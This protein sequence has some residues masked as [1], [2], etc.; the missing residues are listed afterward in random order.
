MAGILREL[1]FD[2]KP[3]ITTES[4]DKKA[5]ELISKNGVVPSFL[6]YKGYPAALCTSLNEEIIHT[7]PSGR[8][9]VNG[10]IITL[11]L[12][13]CFEGYHSDMAVTLP[14][15]EVGAETMRLLK[16]CKKALKRGVKKARD[17]STTGDV[18]NTIERFVT[19]QG[20]SIVKNLCGHGIGRELHMKP[21]VPNVGRRGKG[22]VLSEGD[23][24][25]IE[26]MIAVGKGDIF[27]DKKTGAFLTRDGSLSAHF[28]HTV[29]VGRSSGK[30]LT[31]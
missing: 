22:D 27:E 5:R 16:V 31:K 7:P 6:G 21:D 1:S 25:C 11:D 4:L 17:G 18:G 9:L 13:V 19:S 10:D 3:G 29:M 2:V 12:G 14:V 28:E 20:F 26:P 8:V 30:V 24:I 23:T 15:G